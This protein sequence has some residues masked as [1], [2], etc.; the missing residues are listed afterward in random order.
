MPT[1][2][3]SDHFVECSDGQTRDVCTGGFL[4]Y[5]SGIRPLKDAIGRLLHD[6]DDPASDSN[7]HGL[8][9]SQHTVDIRI[10]AFT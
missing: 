2:W 5:P 3:W 4:I 7:C 8:D 9:P 6:I 10:C 1:L